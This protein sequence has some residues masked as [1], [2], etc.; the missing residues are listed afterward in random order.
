LPWL[1]GS[2]ISNQFHAHGLLIALMMKAARTS[3]TMVNFHQTTWHNNPE[4][5]YLH[6]HRCENLKS[7]LI[8]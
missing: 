5:S 4:Y 7:Y 2:Y 3:E 6:T 8:I 1:T